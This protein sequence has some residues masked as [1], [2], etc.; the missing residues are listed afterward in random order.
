MKIVKIIATA[1]MAAV[2]APP[3]VA[4]NAPDPHDPAAKKILDKVQ[5][6][7]QSYETLRASFDWTLEN[8]TQKTKDSKSGFMFIKG[9]KYKLI[10][11]GIE[12]F[13]DGTTM[14]TYSKDANEIT[15]SDVEEDDESITS[16]PTKIFDLYQ[17]GFKYALKGEEQ[18][19]VKVKKD[20][21]IVTEKKTCHIVDLYPESP[22][23][24][25]FHTVELAIEKATT[26]IV[27]I[28]IKFKNGSDQIIEIT[29]YKP[30]ATMADALFTYDP[31]KYP[32]VEVNDMR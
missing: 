20:G 16:N 3:A 32:G 23:G 13:S 31:A 30:N 21:K 24:K 17:K 10:L 8:K 18:R 2:L 6:T 14:W 1:L 12:M 25:E 19:N 7:T 5:Q 9:G 11:S 27:S 29:E 15:I 28:D 26:Q 4:Q 22:K